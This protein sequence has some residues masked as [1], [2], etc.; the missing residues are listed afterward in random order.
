MAVYNSN[1]ILNDLRKQPV[2]I[3]KL[4]SLHVVYY[5]I[6]NPHII[7]LGYRIG[8]YVCFGVRMDSGT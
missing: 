8:V 3:V 7:N 5:Y 1:M 6:C 4:T 2:K